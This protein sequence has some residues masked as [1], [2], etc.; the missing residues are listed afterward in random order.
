[1][2]TAR[3]NQYDAQGHL[4]ILRRKGPRDPIPQATS[5]HMDATAIVASHCGDVR[6]QVAQGR[7]WPQG[8]TA[9]AHPA[10]FE[11]KR[12]ERPPAKKLDQLVEVTGRTS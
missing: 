2:F 12:L 10:S 4:R 3:G 1:M 5:D 9:F 7:P 6:C 8:G 11:R